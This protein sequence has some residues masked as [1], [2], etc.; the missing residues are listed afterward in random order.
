L[1]KNRSKPPPSLNKRSPA[2]GI[3]NEASVEAADTYFQAKD[4]GLDDDAAQEAALKTYWG[5]VGILSLSDPLQNAL[6]F[7]LLPASGRL[8]R[9]GQRMISAGSEGFEEV[10][11]G[12]MKNK[13]LG[14]ENNWEQLGYEWVIGAASPV[15]SPRVRGVRPAWPL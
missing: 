2:S 11:Q 7:G 12:F 1:S 15:S 4:M 3:H 6:T 13:A 10:A 5:N 14:Q 8:A 9:W